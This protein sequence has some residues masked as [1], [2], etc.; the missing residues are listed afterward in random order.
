M[1]EV[2]FWKIQLQIIVRELN[3]IVVK[4]NNGFILQAIA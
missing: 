4:S 3:G 1:I 2:A